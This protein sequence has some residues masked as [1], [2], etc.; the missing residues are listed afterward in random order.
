MSVY[1]SRM[2]PSAPR[3]VS[4]ALVASLVA[5][6]SCASSSTRGGEFRDASVDAAPAVDAAPDAN[7]E[8]AA[9]DA[10]PDAVTPVVTCGDALCTRPEETCETCPLDCGECPVCDLAPTCTGATAAPTSTSELADCNSGTRSNYSCGTGLGVPASETTCAD[11]QLRI[12]MK[13]LSIR[14]GNT[15]SARDLYC[16]ISAEDGTHSELMV[17]TPRGVSGG[18][19]TTNINLGL[20]ESIA[21]GQGDL[22]RSISN[23]TLTYSCYITDD[24]NRAQGILD[25]IADRAGAVAEYAGAYGWVFGAVSVVGGVI[26]SAIGSAG[27]QQVLSVQQTIDAGALLSMTNGRSWTVYQ[28]RGDVGD[29]LSGRNAWTI[30]LTMESWGCANVRTVLM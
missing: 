5:L 3:S 20:S 17:M 26:G 27:D 4:L 13:S 22:Y 29:L 18:G 10:W 24:S 11:P 21:W 9:I 30:T 8:D 2:R 28:E 16:T 6:T 7:A 12:R 23:I 14:R 25:G 19:R 1:G 15:T